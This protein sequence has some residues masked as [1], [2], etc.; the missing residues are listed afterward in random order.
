MRINRERFGFFFKRLALG[1][2][3]VKADGHL[4]EDALAAALG[5]G[6]SGCA[7]QDSSLFFLKSILTA[8]A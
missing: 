1:I 6:M 2:L 3:T 8:A 7:G 5:T 4:H